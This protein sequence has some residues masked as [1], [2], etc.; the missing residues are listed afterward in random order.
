[1]IGT[2]LKSPISGTFTST[3][4][5]KSTSPGLSCATLWPAAFF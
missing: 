2:S 5:V 4:L 3:M 1:M